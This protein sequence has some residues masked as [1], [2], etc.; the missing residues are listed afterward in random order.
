M[1]DV[2]RACPVCGSLEAEVILNVETAVMSNSVLP[3][4]F[5]VVTCV[6]CGFIYQDCGAKLSDYE[7]YYKS[8]NKYYSSPTIE[9]ESRELFLNYIGVLRK[10]INKNSC[11]LDMGCAGGAFLALLSDH[12]Y[13]CLAGVDPS[14]EAVWAINSRGIEAC[15]GGVYSNDLPFPEKRFDLIVLSGVMEHLYDLKGAV[16]NIGKYLN[17]GG[18]IF[19]SVPDVERYCEYDNS[20]SYYFNLEHINHFSSVSLSNLMQQ[21]GYSCFDTSLYSI[22]F[23]DST[24]P[25]FSSLFKKGG[26]DSIRTRKDLVS[27]ESV[28]RYLSNAETK[29]AEN[30]R[31]IDAL[32][33]SGEELMIWGAGSV[34][35]GMIQSTRLGSCNIKGF[36]DK[37]PGKQGKTISGIKINRPD[38]LDGFQGTIVVCAALYS[39]DILKEISAMG[40]KNKVVVLK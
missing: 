12:G 3:G 30:F 36:V 19:V 13:T 15:L 37:D 10:F 35:S 32:F 40:L 29:R 38:A 22:R 23:G 5:S 26:I 18:M 9:K 27:A 33:K 25:A 11:I 8:S 21:Y 39:F 34:A 2:I 20:V 6:T 14:A 28:K 17:D 24:V 1:A 4:E 31:L 16:I 7:E